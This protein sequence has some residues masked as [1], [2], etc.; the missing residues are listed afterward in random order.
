MVKHQ[1]HSLDATFSALADPTR[2]A[3]LLRLADGEASVSELAAPFDMSLPAISKHLTVLEK[4]GLL[5]RRKEGRVHHI[6][7]AAKPMQ[8]AAQWLDFYEQFWSERLDALDDLLREQEDDS[9]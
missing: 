3:I 4:A 5:N 7:L 6:S 8:E 9:A 1:Y 2:R